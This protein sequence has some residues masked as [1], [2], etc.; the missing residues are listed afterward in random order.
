MKI[1]WKISQIN[2]IT[3]KISSLVVNK[4]KIKIKIHPKNLNKVQTKPKTKTVLKD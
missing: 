3:K 2:Y 4:I 1:T